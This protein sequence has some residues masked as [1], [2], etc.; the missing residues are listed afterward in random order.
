[1]VPMS[2]AAPRS[3]DEI[4]AVCLEA[5]IARIFRLSLT[6]VRAW[7]RMPELLPFPPLPW[8]DRQ[9]R[10]SGCVVAWFLTQ[11]AGEYRRQ[12]TE[13]LEK[14]AA[15]GHK[16]K[17][18]PWWRFTAPHDPRFW[19]VPLESEGPTL[20]LKDVAEALRTSPYSLRR[21]VDLPDFPMPPATRRPLRWTPG[22]LER[23]LSAPPDHKGSPRRARGTAGKR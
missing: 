21:A 7:R 20:S 17:R 13:P 14:L 8:M 9:L 23:L 15:A 22:Q 10:V 3:V 18:V 5:D 2:E 1:M 6:E 19:A 4:P 11:E 12:V 16:R